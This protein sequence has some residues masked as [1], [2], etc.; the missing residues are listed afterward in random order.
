MY[1]PYRP[2]EKIVDRAVELWKRMLKNPKFDNGD[3]SP[4]GFFAGAMAKT[5]P[6]N[7]TDEILQVFG[8]NLKTALMNPEPEY[9]QEFF[10]SS[11]GVDY[12]PDKVLHDAANKAGLKMEFPWKTSM[13]LWTEHVSVSAGYGAE[14]VYH[15]P[16]ADGRWLMTTLCG[17]DISK[18]IAYC[19]GKELSFEI[20]GQKV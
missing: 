10:H 20:E 16:L 3:P 4:S 18:I 13:S 14:R 17:S 6:N 11:L 7:A 12:G 2:V 5:I 19:E 1:E 8:E 15:Y 9:K